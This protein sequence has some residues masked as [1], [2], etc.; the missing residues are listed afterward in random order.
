M[1][2][3]INFY[4]TLILEIVRKNCQKVLQFFLFYIMMNMT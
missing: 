3:K 1:I 4:E 2:I